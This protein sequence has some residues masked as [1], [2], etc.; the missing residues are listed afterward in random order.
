MDDALKA[1][2][3]YL[4]IK[5]PAGSDPAMFAVIPK[6]KEDSPSDWS[7]DISTP[8]TL[9]DAI[10]ALQPGGYR[11]HEVQLESGERQTAINK[12]RKRIGELNI[13]DD[14]KQH[15]RDRLDA[16]RSIGI[17]Y[18][19]EVLS[20][21]VETARKALEDI[22]SRAPS[23]TAVKALNNSGRVGGYLVVWGNPSQKDLQGEYFTPETELGLDWYDQRPAL[24]HHGLDGTMQ[25]TPIGVIDKVKADQTGVWAEAQLNLR[26][27]YVQAVLNLINQGILAWSSGSLPHLVQTAPDGQIKRWPIVEGSM[28]PTPAEPRHT[29][30][31]AIKSAY[32][33]L[34]LDITR[35]LPASE[36]VTPAKE[37]PAKE[38]SVKASPDSGSQ[39]SDSSSSTEVSTPMDMNAVLQALLKAM[40]AQFPDLQ[41]TPD[42]A[43]QIISDACNALNTGAGG[44][45][46]APADGSAPAATMSAQQIVDKAAPIIG[47][48]LTTLATAQVAAR[49]AADD[50]VQAAAKNFG[51]T[52]RQAPPLPRVP[53]FTGQSP[54]DA[55]KSAPAVQMSDRR[56]DHLSAPEMA[57][58][59]LMLNRLGK[60][61]SPDYQLAAA[62]K[63]AQMMERG[64]KAANDLAVKSVFPFQKPNDVFQASFP[65][66]KANEVMGPGQSG[67][68]TEYVNTYYSTTVWEVVRQETPVY[69]RM[70]A[71]G[72]DEKEVPQG[73]KSDTIPLEGA[74]MTWYVGGPATDEDTSSGRV[75]PVV[76]SSKFATGQKEVT[77]GKLT[78]RT[79]WDREMDE[80]SIVNILSEANR[81]IRISGTEQI[82]NIL[83][84]GDTATGANTNI[85]S[86]D[87]TP[88]TG[89][90]KPSY[91]LLDG[92]M[93]LALVTNT[94]QT[95]NAAGTL[96]EAVFLNLLPLLGPSG[97]YS[98]DPDKILFI[99][100]NFVYFAAL[101]LA[102]LKTQDVFPSATI[103]DGML[104]KIWGTELLRSAQLGKANTNG[105]VATTTPANNTTGRILLVRP[106]QWAARW[107]REIEIFTDFDPH[108][109]TTFL[110]A[111]MRWG[112]GY[113]ANDAASI[114][115]NVSLTIA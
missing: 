4:A 90:T 28:T 8:E 33:D 103:V 12:I 62:Y 57:L 22:L 51:S 87:G 108:S 84:N 80:D 69:G 29:D 68:G 30:I 46:A 92:L 1:F 50:A 94:A 35:L 74:D 71:K 89:T 43:N 105:K 19:A 83:L 48:A 23:P 31:N 97:K 47:K 65:G 6:G 113:R 58:G 98:S 11:G 55:N 73:Y 52:L 5:A 17:E 76:A 16:L 67:F 21:N 59:M 39:S 3:T 7:L 79:F 53:G 109:D 111:H 44:D 41:V 13:S 36:D 25:A 40:L 91:L 81:K 66:I 9:A 38:P 77:L 37:P 107:K 112:L 14:Q 60:N 24:Y 114:A 110:V 106:D 64:D 88:G 27:K 56:F 26:N 102:V 49:K 34:G 54:A 100:D 63:T 2:L 95:Y 75:T 85:N 20:V 104:R 115:R 45:A 101:N 99:V 18:L 32:A 82:E 93:K 15:L 42:Q 96:A 10:T 86:I 78:A 72:M 70:V 61:I